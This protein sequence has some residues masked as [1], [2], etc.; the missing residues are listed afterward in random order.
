MEGLSFG[1]HQLVAPLE[2][3]LQQKWLAWAE[4]QQISVSGLRKAIADSKKSLPGQSKFVFSAATTENEHF[5]YVHLTRIRNVING[6]QTLTTEQILE[7]AIKLK[8]FA[9]SVIRDMGGE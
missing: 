1:H 9:E 6:K 2:A 3:E 8:E 4:Q 5:S 7:D